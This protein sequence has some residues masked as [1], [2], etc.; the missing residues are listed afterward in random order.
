MAQGP[1]VAVDC[2]I[3]L[4]DQANWPIV[5]VERRNEPRGWALP[6]GFA[7]GNESAEQAVVREVMEETGLQVKL[8]G[9]LGCYS[10][11]GRDP[12]GP[13]WSVVF[14]AEATGQPKG[15][16]DAAKAAFFP[17]WKLPSPLCFDH[18]QILQDFRQL[19]LFGRSC[20]IACT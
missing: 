10:Q 18:G 8:V 13:V 16:D 17:L 20:N 9:Q 1:R 12:R 6:G 2:I 5:L 4:V 3:T 19:T 15:G 11:P 14:L 7:E